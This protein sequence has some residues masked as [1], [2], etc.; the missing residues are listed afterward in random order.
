MRDARHA[1]SADRV[2]AARTVSGHKESSSNADGNDSSSSALDAAGDNDKRS[3]IHVSER[4][5]GSFSRSWK[6]EDDVTEDDIDA[7]FAN[8]VLHLV[9]KKKVPSPPPTP[10]KITINVK[11]D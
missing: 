8:G 4:Y 5:Y 7:Q 2:R 10:K 9:V 6:L 3:K 11:K 1:T